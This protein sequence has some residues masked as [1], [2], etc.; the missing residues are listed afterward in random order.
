MRTF[1][2][3]AQLPLRDR[4]AFSGLF[5]LEHYFPRSAWIKARKQMRRLR[6]VDQLQRRRAGHVLPV[7]R[8]SGLSPA[9]F[10]ANYLAKGIPVILENAAATWPLATRW[11]FDN[12]KQRFGHET[13][14]LV[15]RKGV[16]REDEVVDGREYSEEIGFG[17][18]LDQVL[19]GGKKYMR[20]S[21][22]LEK[23][24]ELVDDFNHDF[25][26]QMAGN[27]WGVTYQLFLGGAGSYTPLHNAMTSFFF[28]NVT[29]IKR[30]ALI[31]NH[32][33]PVLNPVADGFGYNHSGARVAP[34][35]V[36]EFPGLDRIDR[37]QT[38]LS[39]G[40]VLFV[41][42]W[43]W[44]CVKNDSATIGIRC[45]II[46]PRGMIRESAALTF[47]RLFAARNPST[48]EALYY[49]LFKK[50]LPDRDRWLLTP[51]VMRR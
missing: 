13:I 39:P 9:D 3:M 1:A 2:D 24:P 32:Y 45:G 16:A 11:S 40:D 23:F 35:N 34:L 15:Q 21:P 6:V 28:V 25:F 49:A 10:R 47:I 7:E 44:H 50:N 27:R 4:A 51:R 19:S 41:P 8:V 48:F 5:L 22:L 38:T 37:F 36:D 30:W 42:S 26:A 17:D 18:F 46:Y 33:L 31:P 20:F 12:F 43:L 14:K 29:G